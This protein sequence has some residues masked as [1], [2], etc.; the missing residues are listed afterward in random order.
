MVTGLHLC[1]YN[2]AILVWGSWANRDDG[3]LW[4]GVR[5]GR[6]GQEDSGCSFLGIESKVNMVNPGYYSTL[7]HRFWLETLDKNTVEKGN[8]SLNGFECRLRG[9]KG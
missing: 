7:T 1:W 3:C 5:R 2:F 4:Q 9:L 6:R 8:Q